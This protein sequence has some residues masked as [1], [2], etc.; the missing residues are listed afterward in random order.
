MYIRNL[1]IEFEKLESTENIHSAQTVTTTSHKD[2]L[3]IKS[4]DI[5]VRKNPLSGL[6]SSGRAQR[7]RENLVREL[8]NKY[9]KQGEPRK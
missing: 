2:W 4:V 6:L 3:D 1:N 5:S 8:F 7:E 9:H